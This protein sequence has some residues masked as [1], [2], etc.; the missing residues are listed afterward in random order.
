MFRQPVL[1]ETPWRDFLLLGQFLKVVY[2]T[3]KS[4]AWLGKERRNY[5]HLLEV[6][7]PGGNSPTTEALTSLEDARPLR[8]QVRVFLKLTCWSSISYD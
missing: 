7:L 3:G 1:V 8:E 5:S 4:P 6:T 2:L